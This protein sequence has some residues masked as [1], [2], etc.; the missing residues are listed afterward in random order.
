MGLR[1]GVDRSKQS[2]GRR[3]QFHFIDLSRL[4]DGVRRARLRL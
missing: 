3:V 2:G 4:V 1:I